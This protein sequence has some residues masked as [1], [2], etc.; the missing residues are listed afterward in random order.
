ML[1]AFDAEF[2]FGVLGLDTD[3]LVSSYGRDLKFIFDLLLELLE[4][5]FDFGVDVALFF[6]WPTSESDVIALGCH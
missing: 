6:H 5:F 4:L 1:S 2:A 3:H